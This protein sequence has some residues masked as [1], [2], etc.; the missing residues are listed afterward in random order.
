MQFVSFWV[1]MAHFGLV[2]LT[3]GQFGLLRVSLVQDW[4][5]SKHRPAV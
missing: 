3:L 1:I 4:I 5:V 2:W